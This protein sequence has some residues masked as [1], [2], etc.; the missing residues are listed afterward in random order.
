MLDFLEFIKDI[1]F[2]SVSGLFSYF[3]NG[4]QFFFAIFTK[5]P[6]FLYSTFEALPDFIQFGLTG[7]FGFICFVVVLKI[8]ALVFLQG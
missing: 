7:A 3:S 4:F 1:L 2:N 5:L 8:L 6:S